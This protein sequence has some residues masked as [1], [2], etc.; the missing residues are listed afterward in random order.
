MRVALL[1]S[2]QLR[3]VLFSYP[4][5]KEK[6]LNKF[7]PDVFVSTWNPEADWVVTQ[8]TATQH[9]Q[10]HST[11][12]EVIALYNPKF[13]LSEDFNSDPIQ[14]LVKNAWEMDIYTPMNGESNPVSVMVMW[15]KIKSSLELMLH[16]ERMQGFK[17]D[18][19]IKGR[20][21]LTFHDDLEINPDPS[22][23]S[24]PPGYDWR[25]GIN[26][27]LAYGGREPMQWY[28]SLYDH[29]R[30]YV[31]N[32]EI[33]FHPE[34]LMKHHLFNSKFGI[35]R[36]NIRVSLREHNLWEKEV[37]ESNFKNKDI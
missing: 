25:G 13:I 2:G 26:D 11:L 19:I 3:N 6:I 4:S 24:I 22:F 34:T 8:P 33:L 20:F 1:L 23:I 12:D 30:Y 28:C 17:Y 36:P 10:N 31:M 29:I 21:E 27:I 15:Y 14:R 32:N 5:I 35:N 9:I 16:Y 18:L 7:N 37:L